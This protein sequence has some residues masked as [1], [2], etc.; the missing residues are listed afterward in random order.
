MSG[1]GA[2]VGAGFGQAMDLASQPSRDN[3]QLKYDKRYMDLSVE[4]QQALDQSRFDLAMKQW[5]KTNYKAQM[6]QMKKAGLNPASMYSGAFQG[7]QAQMASGSGVGSQQ[8]Q[9]TRMMEIGAQIGAQTSLIKAQARNL[10]ADA[11]EQEMKNEVRKDVG[12]NADTAE[13]T[14][15]LNKA[16]SEGR[17]LYGEWADRDSGYKSFGDA[18]AENR[19]EKIILNKFSLQE[20]ETRIA[21]ETEDSKKETVK[22]KLVNEYYDVLTK[23]ANIS[24]TKEKERKIW[25]DIWQG[26]ANAGFK[27]LD[28]IIKGVIAKSLGK[29]VGDINWGKGF[30]AGIDSMKGGF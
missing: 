29:K 18:E 24:F 4:A 30:K 20:I 5:E 28:L 6:E 17:M 23:Q 9:K 11:E 21:K 14:N 19:A 10:N 3:Q 7:A 13:A 8:T 27:G 12:Q 2:I 16:K 1:I 22:W 15:R 26:W 25:H